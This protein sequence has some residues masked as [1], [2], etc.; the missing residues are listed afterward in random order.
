VWV[1]KANHRH[2][3]VYLDW[4]ETGIIYFHRD[5]SVQITADRENATDYFMFILICYNLGIQL[6]ELEIQNAVI[7][8]MIRRLRS[9]PTA[10]EHFVGMLTPTT[11]DN[12]VHRNRSDKSEPIYR[13]TIEAVAYFGSNDQLEE[14]ARRTYHGTF[15]ADL[16]ISLAIL[17]G[18]SRLLKDFV[19]DECE[20]HWWCA[21]AGHPCA[22]RDQ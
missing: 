2:F 6:E 22:A 14:I 9:D 10:G 13:L 17:R 4:Q 15:Q 5:L 21:A 20:Y 7:S 11:V 1:S 12:V 3:E 19:E 16:I 8:D 18:K